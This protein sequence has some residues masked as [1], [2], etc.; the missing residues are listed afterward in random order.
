MRAGE[1]SKMPPASDEQIIRYLLDE[2]SAEE[3]SSLEEHLSRDPSFFEQIA[4]AE[5]DMIMRYVRGDLEGRLLPRFTEVYLNSRARQARVDQARLLQQSV[6]N[7]S[8]S[9]KPGSLAFLPGSRRLA[10]AIASVAA[11]IALAIL[12]LPVWKNHS[13][14][15]KPLDDHAQISFAVE[16]GLVRGGAGALL[17]LPPG[18]RQVEFRLALPNSAADGSYRVT[19]ETPERP[20]LWSG[21]VARQGSTLVASIPADKLQPGDYTLKLLSTGAG[22]EEVATYYFRVAR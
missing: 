21:V 13:S 6:R 18:T 8:Q 1:Q 11:V 2:M 14:Q 7:A 17:A 4:A 20:A 10:F 12:L 16:P 15:Q 9:G 3:R 19:L 22:S 5:D